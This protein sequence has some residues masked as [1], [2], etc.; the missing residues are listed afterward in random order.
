MEFRQLN[1][2]GV[3]RYLPRMVT[4]VALLCT[5]GVAVAL[6]LQAMDDAE[7][8]EVTGQALFVSDRIA[9][10][11]SAG[12][13]TDF[14][15]YRMGLDIELL[16]NANIDK[17]QLG[18]GG[19]N[20]S[21]ASNACDIDFDFVRFMGRN[22][23]SAGNAVTS[24]FKLLRPYIELAVRNDGT[25]SLREIAG[26]KIGAQAADG[27]VGVGRRYST[28]GS[29]LNQENGGNCTGTSGTAAL[30]CHSGINRISGYLNTE[31]S[32]QFPVSIPL[33][34]TQTACF[35]N[36]TFNGDCNTPYFVEIV[37]SRLDQIRVPGVPLTLSAGFLSAIGIDQAYATIEQSL[38]F[39]HG[40][41]LEDT[42]DFYL[43]FQ[44]EQ[45]A[46][47]TYD[48][49]GYAV[50]ANAGWWM[51]VPQV[52]VVDFTGAT[53]SLPIDDALEALGSPGPV[54]A[55]SELNQT[56]P[57]NCFGSAMFC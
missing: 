11:G 24:D 35:G 34:G 49:S 54:V 16:M 41:A 3:G 31:L 48:K 17:L 37:G 47:P 45:V 42:D 1:L 29:P 51:N 13:A 56:P 30:N 4:A 12:S 33:L 20:E 32:G 36:V 52:K 5:A 55:N 8:A 18:C 14:T 43:S 46:Y 7:L 26:I 23:T 40:F 44:R 19:F 39:I 27:F 50:T 10:T 28:S 15:F 6:D 9:P 57:L 38:R 2:T 25:A 21:I 53:V 22:G